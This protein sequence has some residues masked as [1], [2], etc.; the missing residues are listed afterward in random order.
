MRPVSRR[1]LQELLATRAVQ[2]LDA[3]Q[4]RQLQQILKGHPEWDD[5]GFDL[6][7]AAIDLALQRQLPEPPAALKERLTARARTWIT[8]AAGQE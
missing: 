4:T 2:G 6:A 8:P 1:R 5:E 3:A 7:A